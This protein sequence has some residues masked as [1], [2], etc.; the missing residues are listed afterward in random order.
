MHVQGT[1][2]SV[3]TCTLLKLCDN[4]ARITTASILYR[5][6]LRPKKDQVNLDLPGPGL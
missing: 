2:L 3:Q 5:K 4:L 1:M 6:K